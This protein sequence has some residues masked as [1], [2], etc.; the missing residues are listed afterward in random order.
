VII[1]VNNGER[2]EI[3]GIAR[4]AAIAVHTD[5]ATVSVLSEDLIKMPLIGAEIAAVGARWSVYRI[6]AANPQAITLNCRRMPDG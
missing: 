3:E 1:Q 4:Q 2:I 6:N 5:T